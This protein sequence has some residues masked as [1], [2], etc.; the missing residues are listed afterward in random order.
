MRILI[1]NDDSVS[2][3]GLVP[4]VRF[5]QKYGQVT[6]VVPKFEQSGKSHGIELLKPFEA[7]QVELEPGITAWVVD[8][9]PA[10]CVR[11]AIHG[12]H[13]QFDLC[14]SGINRGFNMGTDI[15]YSGTVSAA[16]E[17]ALQ[18][19]NSLAV[20]TSRPYYEEAVNH[21]EQVFDFIFGNRLFEKNKIYNVNIPPQG[22]EFLITRQGG[23]FF[24]DDYQE[25]E[26]D[27][28]QR[29]LDN[30][31]IHDAQISHCGY[32]MVFPSGKIDY[33]YN[34]GKLVVQAGQQ[35]CTDLLDGGFVE[36]GLVNKLYRKELFEG[37]RDWLD[38]SIRII[39][40][41]LM[42]FYLFRQVK[43][44]FFEDV[45]PYHYVL[46]KGSAATSK[47]NDHKLRDPLRVLKLLYEETKDVP[48]WNQI[49]ER[50]MMYQ[51]VG[52]STMSLGKQRK[53]IKPVRKEARKELRQRLLRTLKSGTCDVKL[54]IM[55]LWAAVW[56]AS[57]GWVHRIYAKLTGVDKKYNVE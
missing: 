32:K 26:P 8:S 22:K 18:G 46:R 15:L 54:K 41:L 31:R 35:G 11:F 37:L 19:V 13:L 5:C 2:A 6:T 36:P 1:V 40:D 44:A 57:Y 53:L 47:V 24:S 51:L 27:M 48:A 4:L 30:A 45:C 38:T 29:L 3:S 52:S 20:S 28:Y 49:V 17:A 34:S 55:V 16:C 50:R 33:Y 56:P 9:T 25:V 14:I 10:D 23:P 12:M 43:T 7:K 39:E 42:K 21:M